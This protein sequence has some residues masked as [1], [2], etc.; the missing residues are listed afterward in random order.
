MS[1]ADETTV[2][3]RTVL[4]G[5]LIAFGLGAVALAAIEASKLVGRRY[6]PSPFDD[7]LSQIPDRDNA[8]VL[9]RSVLAQERSFDAAAA[10]SQLRAGLKGKSLADAMRDELGR[11]DTVEVHGWILPRSLV[12]LSALAARAA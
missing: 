5:G 7:L 8:A 11:H 4:A 6:K 3:R 1:A 2:P 12:L 9:G 10:A